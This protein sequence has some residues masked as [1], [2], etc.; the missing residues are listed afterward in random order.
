[1]AACQSWAFGPGGDQ[2]T[3]NATQETAA[4]Q[5]STAASAD[6]RW[7]PLANAMTEVNALP[8]TDVS[9]DQEA[10]AEKDLGTIRSECATT[11]VAVP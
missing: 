7:Q 8:E 6:S 9:S 2:Q 10:T 1:M 4:A 3:R 11:G 5:A